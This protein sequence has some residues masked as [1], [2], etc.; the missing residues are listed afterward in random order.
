MSSRFLSVDPGIELGA[1]MWDY[2]S[3]ENPSVALTPICMPPIDT[4]VFYPN[5]D[6]EWVEGVQTTIAKLDG[7]ISR[8]SD[9]ESGVSV[10][11]C[12]CEW[13]AFFEDARVA[14]R[15]GALVKLAAAVGMVIELCRHRNIMFFQ[16]PVHKWK[17][18]MPKEAVINRIRKRLPGHEYR[19]HAWDAVG[20]G[21]WAK[22][23]FE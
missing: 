4:G 5:K 14:A 3:S 1:A 23:Y 19:S 13:P 8:N 9:P 11:Q 15:D 17:G 21:L 6:L 22:G 2:E 16:V 7:F 18:Q 10:A 20:I 12:F